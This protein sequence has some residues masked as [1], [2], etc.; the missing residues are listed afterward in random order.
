MTKEQ[1]EALPTGTKLKDKV[2]RTGKIVKVNSVPAI[3]MEIKGGVKFI[4]MHKVI[5]DQIEIDN[6]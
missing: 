1:L 6:G 4:F 5:L 3:R 2:G